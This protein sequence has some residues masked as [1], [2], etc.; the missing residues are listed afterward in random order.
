[1]QKIWRAQDLSEMGK[2]VESET[3]NFY[4]PGGRVAIK[5]HMGER[6]GR[7]FLDPVI[8]KTIVNT[9][10]KNGY[11]P[12]LF[13]SPVVYPGGRDTEAAYYKTAAEH[14]Y[15]KE[16]MDCPVVISDRAT[17][18]EVKG[19]VFEVCQEVAQ[20]DGLFVLTH[21]K[22][23]ECTAMGGAVKNLGMGAVTRKSKRAMHDLAIPKL[24]G[25][26]T[27]CATCIKV[28]PNDSVKLVDEKF[29]I[30]G[31]CYGCDICVVNCPTQAL[32]P[33]ER[34][35]D[36]F[37]AQAAVAVIKSVPAVYGVNVLQKIVRQCDCYTGKLS[38]IAPDVGFVGGQDIV[39]LD[40]ATVDLITKR[41]GAEV[42][43]KTW[44]KSPRLQLEE[45][46]RLKVGHQKYELI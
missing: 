24:V 44:N 40:S 21:I 11:R 5:L 3:K 31:P 27:A 33:V 13:D 39:A 38:V 28:C 10:K 12:F 34:S 8:A 25:E 29:S 15:T 36:D 37:I 46:E 7:Y 9:L 17:S 22:G 35:I 45:M 20:S 6:G 32:Q 2:L 30:D 42:F 4:E 26:C 1:M 23:H 14:G 16:K 43:E 41:A 18:V 19:F